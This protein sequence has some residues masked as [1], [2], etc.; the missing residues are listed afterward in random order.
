VARKATP[1]TRGRR[2]PRELSPH[3]KRLEGFKARHPGIADPKSPNYD[4]KW[5]QLARGHK[6]A[7]HVERKRR[8][9]ERYGATPYQRKVIRDFARKQARRIPEFEN[10]PARAARMQAA[11]ERAIRAHGYERFE[12]WRDRVD[13]LHKAKRRRVR[14]RMRKQPDGTIVAV[15]SGS[16]TGKA[17]RVARMEAYASDPF[18]E[19]LAADIDV[20]S[21]E[22]LFYH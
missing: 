13:R 2:R 16:D 15:F 10:D 17:Q 7:E 11:I 9:T 14:T 12:V 1:A 5:K 6:P 19:A 4:P 8:E 3:E 20:D 18:L 22:L 21:F